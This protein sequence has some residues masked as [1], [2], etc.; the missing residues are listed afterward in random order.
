MIKKRY[1]TYA[2]QIS[3]L[4]RQLKKL[5]KGKV[6]DEEVLRAVANNNN[7]KFVTQDAA[8]LSEEYHWRNL[9]TR[10]AIFP[11]S[12]EVLDQIRK[13]KFKVSMTEG[14][15]PPFE[16]FMLCFP[17]GYEVDG[18]RLPGCLVTDMA[19]EKRVEEVFKPTLKKVYST[20]PG[21]ADYDTGRFIA[22]N[23]RVSHNHKHRVC[24]PREQLPAVLEAETPQEVNDILGLLEYPESFNNDESMNM[25]F[26][27]IKIIA[28]IYI[29]AQAESS[30]LKAGFPANNRP[31]IEG[32]QHKKTKD[33][34]L[35][36]VARKGHTPSDHYRSGHYRQL[37]AERFYRNEHADKP[38]GSRFIWVKD[39]YVGK[40]I[41]PH[42]LNKKKD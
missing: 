33:F 13:T 21:F 30:A 42:T 24:I 41:D 22:I 7:E 18:V 12:K 17:Q 32:G 19:V 36:S 11:E 31:N 4:A 39:T 1:S 26:H 15:L 10:P 29:Y 5:L 28:A 16:T 20:L 40:E 2:F 3:Q 23:F 34:T 25:Q 35:T 14:I 9:T 37:T 38:V 27:L 8:F 6:S